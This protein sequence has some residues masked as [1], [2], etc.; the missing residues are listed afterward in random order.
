MDECSEPSPCAENASCTNNIGSFM[1]TCNPG[2]AG[3][4]FGLVCEDV[5]ECAG[6]HGC[7]ENSNCSNTIGSYECQAIQGFRMENGEVEDVDEC[8]NNPCHQNAD[9]ENT[10]GGFECSCKGLRMI[11]KFH[12]AIFIRRLS[13]NRV[14]LRPDR[15]LL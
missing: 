12:E 8:L 3:D 9:C 14:D 6:D 4:P 10:V 5:N 15:Q 13:R 11:I 1:C 7:P 2:F